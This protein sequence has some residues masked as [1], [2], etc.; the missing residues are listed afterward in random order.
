[1]FLSGNELSICAC[2]CQDD[3]GEEDEEEEDEEEEDD[4]EL[5]RKAIALSMEGEKVKGGAD[6]E[7]SKMASVL[8][9]MED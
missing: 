7:L 9:L 3:E 1:M 8:S 4:E 5:L 2:H 6:E